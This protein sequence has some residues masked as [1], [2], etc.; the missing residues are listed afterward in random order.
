MRAG[1]ESLERSVVRAQSLVITMAILAIVLGALLA[2]AVTRSIIGPLA[3]SVAF[4][5]AIAKGDPS[6]SLEVDGED[7]TAALAA[8]LA[9]MQRSLSALIGSILGMAQRVNTAATDMSVPVGNVRAG[10]EAQH[11]AVTQ[12]ASSVVRFA[13]ET[14][15]SAAAAGAARYQAETARDLAK[16]GCGLISDSSRE[17]ARI[18]IIINESGM[19]VEELRDT[20][21]SVRMLLDTVKEVADQTNLLALNASIEAA[22]AGETGRGFAVVA[23]EVRKLADRTS[24]ATTEINTVIDAIDRETSIAV[25]RIGAGRSEMQRGAVLIQAIVPPL[26]CLSEGAQKSLEQL[27]ALSAT[28]DRQVQE[29]NGITESIQRIGDMATDNLDPTEKVASTTV[30]LKSLSVSLSEQVGRFNLA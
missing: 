29:T 14:K 6:V 3:A 17:V 28:L 19:S 25:S 2:W 27:D 11:R 1:R 24:K 15:G 22:R 16:E 23:D 4:A 5:G 20:A 10:S 18:S 26:D 30:V 8:A 21:L 7:E 12:G 9:A 13:R